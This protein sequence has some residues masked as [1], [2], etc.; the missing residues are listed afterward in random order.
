[1]S[2]PPIACACVPHVS[3]DWLR[4]TVSG[5][6]V[7]VSIDTEKA[8]T[9]HGT[10]TLK[11][12]TG[13]VVVTVDAEVVALTPRP[14]ESPEVPAPAQPEKPAARTQ[15]ARTPP[16]PEPAALPPPA[17][18]RRQDTPSA[19]ETV[20]PSTDAS[21]TARPGRTRPP[22]WSV[23]WAM[24]PLLS[25]GFLAPV[26]FVHAA[27]R[28]RSWVLALAGLAYFAC[29]VT[30]FALAQSGKTEDESPLV[31]L[32]L[33]VVA[34]VHAFLL[35]T[36]VFASSTVPSTGLV[37]A[38]TVG[39]APP[40]SHPRRSG[41]RPAPTDHRPDAETAVEI[42]RV[43]TLRLVALGVAGSGKTVFLS[44]MFHTLNVPMTGRAYFLETDAAHRVYLSRM[45]EEVS[46]TGEPWPRGTRAGESRELVLDCVSYREGVRHLVCRI[47]YLDYAGE[48]L[49][50]E[51][52]AGA[53]ALRDLEERIHCAQGLVGML[54]GHRVLQY[55]RNEPAGRR[56]FRSSLQ[57][58]LGMMA[59][60][61]CPVYFVMTKWDLVRGFGEPAD[62]DDATRLALVSQALLGNSQIRALVD[63]H[64]YGNRVVRLF[65]VSAVGPDFALVDSSGHVVKR[66]DG[67][68]KPSRV[69]LPLSA[70]L[71]DLF[72]D[73]DL[74]LHPKLQA[75]VTAAAEARTKLSPVNAERAL[76]T[77]QMAP[78][79]SELR[80]QL[81]GALGPYGDE[82]VSM[83][84]DWKGRTAGGIL[85]VGDPRTLAGAR[86]GVLA[87][88]HEA[89]S[90]AEA[91][92]PALRLSAPR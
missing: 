66:Q 6:Q 38:A 9:R 12:P 30:F 54:D 42:D 27:A 82:L 80:E 56:Y 5:A 10:V 75:V 52:E 44:S 19:D 31:L 17:P 29:L 85:D 13:E 21:E 86:S 2:G 74:S 15:E 57:P 14:A 22:T 73:V 58:I 92:L 78:E 91:D 83:F 79:G 67:Q 53:T 4:V 7:D 3:D 40:G 89:V 60:A 49:E 70:V 20:R 84:L 34:T 64:S 69:E 32:A 25:L 33:V 65:P 90:R 72:G 46:D 45:F 62:A 76:V 43:P 37:E 59:G 68:V 81:E 24:L 16:P 61:T 87:D 50:T 63:A 71:P 88:F 26:P 28:L 36:R 47:S 41:S 18:P 11:G 51:P 35:R 55:L 48:L 23:L 1:M 77:F 39:S 8:G